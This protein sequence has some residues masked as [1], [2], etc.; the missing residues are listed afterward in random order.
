MTKEFCLGQ[1][2][3]QTTARADVAVIAE[4]GLLLTQEGD[5]PVVLEAVGGSGSRAGIREKTSATS[6]SL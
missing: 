2:V 4:R 5:I 3:Y 1:A 6:S